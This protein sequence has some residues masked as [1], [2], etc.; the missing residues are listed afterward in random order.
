M[1]KNSN[2][3]RWLYSAITTLALAGSASLCQAQ[4]LITLSNDSSK[5]PAFYDGGPAGTTYTWIPTGGPN[6]G[7]CIQAV[8]DGVTTLE[9]DPAFNVS[10]TSGQYLQ[11]TLQLKIDPNSGTTGSGG[12]GGFGHLQ[13]ALRDSTYSWTSVGYATIY[14]PAA[15]DWVTYTYSIPSPSFSVAHIQFQLQAGSAYSGSVTGYIGNVSIVPVPNP[16]VLSQFTNSSDVNWSN[17]GMAAAWDS[18]ADAPYYNPVTQSGPTSITPAGSIQFDAATP[19]GY[20]GGQLNKGFNPTLFQWVGMDVYYDG[21]TP[22]TSTDFGGFQLLIAGNGNPDYGWT[23]IGAVNFN[24]SLK[25][26][27]THYNFPCAASG[28]LGANGLA[29]QAIPNGGGA[30]P[31]TFHVDNIQLWNPTTRPTLTALTKNSSAAGLKIAVDGNGTLNQ[32]DQEG[33]GSPSADTA[34]HNLFWTGQTPASYS[35]TLANFPSTAAAPGFNAHCYLVNNDTI[36]G[37]GYNQTYSGVNY[38]TADGVAFNIA[39]NTNG[40]PAAVVATI[41]WKTNM[42]NANATNQTQ[43]YLPQ[44]TSAN[45]TWTF[46]FTGDLNGTLYGPDGNVAGTFSLPDGVQ[47]NFTPATSFVQFGVAKNDGANTG[48]NNDQSAVFTH[49]SVTNN[50]LGTIYDDSFAG[51]GLTGKYA[52]QVCEYYQYAANRTTW[53]PAGTAWWLKWNTTQ[54]GWGVLSSGDLLGAWGDAGVTY[55]YIDGTGTNTIGAIPSA[56]LPPGNAAFFELRK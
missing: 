7:G 50:V 35:F 27:W 29:F 54:S 33:I 22:N 34:T 8:F 26:K 40:G 13:M 25:G 46:T 43:L 44:Y 3:N 20:P 51:P 14:P 18:V 11:V 45:G 41:Q 37:S 39:N 4:S 10:F 21:P 19:S 28:R 42:P 6:G 16:A 52:W 31:I 24:A 47:P 48:V 36:A 1:K 12:S 15:S 30:T 38:N 23:W 2:P 49:V 17:Y 55:K 53:I 5:T 32:F 56:S 9:M